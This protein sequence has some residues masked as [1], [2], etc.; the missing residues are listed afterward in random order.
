[1]FCNVNF[2]NFENLLQRKQKTGRTKECIS[3]FRASGGTNFENFSKFGCGS[4]CGFDGCNGLANGKNRI[5][6]TN[7]CQNILPFEI[8]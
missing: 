8:H 1:M 4:G 7:F 2:S 6:Y 5:N 3:I